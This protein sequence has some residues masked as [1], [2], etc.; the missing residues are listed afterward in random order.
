MSTTPC[1]DSTAVTPDLG[2]IQKLVTRGY[3]FNCSRHLIL[4]VQ[5][6]VH[7]R[8]FLWRLAEDGWVVGAH[9]SRDEMSQRG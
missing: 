7:A 8:K 4:T 9:E 5:D 2:D 3:T 1:P 6:P